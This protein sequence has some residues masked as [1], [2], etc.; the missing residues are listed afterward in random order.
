[1]NGVVLDTS[2]VLGWLHQQEPWH[3]QAMG[4]MQD[5]AAGTL[6]AWVAPTFRFELTNSL[7]RDVG[8]GRLDWQGVDVRLARVDMFRLPV[9]CQPVERTDLLAICRAYGLRWPD[10][11]HVLVAVRHGLPLITADQRLVATL[12]GKP[13]WVESILDRPLD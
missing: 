2:V 6:E 8:R 10:A 3:A 1:M 12:R 9:D 11:H 5:V 4:L 13:V 7:V